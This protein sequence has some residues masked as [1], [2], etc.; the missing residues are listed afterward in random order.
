MKRLLLLIAAATLAHLGYF[1]WQSSDDA[2][3][4]RDAADQLAALGD[5]DANSL[6][7]GTVVEKYPYSLSTAGA[8]SQ[9]A[10][11]Q[12]WLK[13]EPAGLSLRDGLMLG[14]SPWIGPSA[15]MALALVLALWLT[16]APGSRIRI[17]SALL[18]IAALAVSALSQGWIGL[19]GAGSGGD[20]LQ[21]ALTGIDGM[22]YTI[23]PWAAVGALAMGFGLGL[24]PQDPNR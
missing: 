20:I 7:F 12:P 19:S 14:T 6:V 9:L 10:S 23:F 22:A 8:R 15:V 2:G 4:I 3:L 16:F 24:F 11:L 21:I 1:T 18:L 17:L 5:E 13:S